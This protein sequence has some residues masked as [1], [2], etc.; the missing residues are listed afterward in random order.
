MHNFIQ[1]IND[2]MGMTYWKSLCVYCEF[3][4]GLISLLAIS[5]IWIFIIAQLFSQEAFAQAKTIKSEDTMT[6]LRL[7]Y[8][9]IEYTSSGYWE[10]ASLKFEEAVD[11]NPQNQDAH[12]CYLIVSDI[13]DGRLSPETGYNIF[14]AIDAWVYS[15]NQKASGIFNTI[16]KTQKDYGLIFLFKGQNEVALEAFDNAIHDYNKTIKLRPDIAYTYIKRGQLYANQKCYSLALND[17]NKA[18]ELDSMYYEGYFER[19]MVYQI[20]KEYEKSVHDYEKSYY[21]YP[22]L[23]QTLH[24]SLKICEGYNNLGMVYLKSKDYATALNYFNEAIDWNPAFY[25]PYLN[26]GITFRHLHHFNAAI[27]DFNKVLEIDPTQMDSYI[28]LALTY[29]EVGEPEKTLDYLSMVMKINPTTI[30]AYQLSGEIYFDQRKFDQAIS[31]FEKA[32]CLDDHYFWGYYWIALSYDALK[33]YPEAIEA[34]ETYIKTAPEEFYDQKI[35]MYQRA[36]RLKRW[37]ERRQH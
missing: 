34:Y 3:V 23:K 26:R 29:K 8:E 16:L 36:E 28:N 10:L 24:Q 2:S 13:I 6:S 14:S 27:L 5:G 17:F 32:L 15:N 20:L 11:H 30:Q 19:G 12:F 9:G 18:I 35:K 7:F 22:S 33:K 1:N 21:L 4:G 31:M 37:V 25:E